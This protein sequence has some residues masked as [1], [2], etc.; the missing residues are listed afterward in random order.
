MRTIAAANQKGAYGK[1]TTPV[2][3]AAAPA[4][5]VINGRNLPEQLEAS[6]EQTDDRITSVGG[7]IDGKIY[8]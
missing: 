5:E 2:D 6:N 8:Y 7:I 3:L 4:G 1:T